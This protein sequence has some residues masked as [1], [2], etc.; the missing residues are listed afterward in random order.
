M[1]ALYLL[2]TENTPFVAFDSLGLRFEIVGESRPENCAKFFLPITNW[3]ENF[4]ENKIWKNSSASELIFKFKL[5]YFNSTSAK[6]ILD[7]LKIIRQCHENGCKT[8]IHWYSNP[9]DE[10]MKESGEEFSM[11]VEYP[12]EY[13]SL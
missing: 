13:Y 6:Y 5:D 4:N 11:V 1:E 3:L 10:D 9:K 12:F 2:G 7:I 8:Q